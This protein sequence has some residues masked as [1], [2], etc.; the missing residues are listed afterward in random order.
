MDTQPILL[1]LLRGFHVAMLASLFGTLVSQGLV[2]PAALRGAAVAAPVARHRLLRLARWSAALALLLGVGW[3][4]LASAAIAGTVTLSD[5]VAVVGKVAR[6]TR[7]GQLLLFRLALLAVALALLARRN[8]RVVA[9]LLPAGVALGM[10]GLLGHAGA[11]GGSAGVVLLASEAVHLLAAGAWLGGLPP[12]L[13]LVGSL[14]PAAAAEACEN[15]TPVGLGAVVAIAGT[16]AIQSWQLIGGLA[17]LLGTPYGHLALLKA[18]LFVALL[19]LAGVNR[20]VLTGRLRHPLRAATRPA[21]L[22]SIGTETGLGVA[23]IVLAAFLASTMPATHS[24]PVWPFPHHPVPD[25]LADPVARDRSP[26][27]AASGR[28]IAAHPT[29]V[30]AGG[31]R[32]LAP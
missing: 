16:A 28:D 17:R 20:L 14:P 13:L 7:F 18:G 27:R 22:A 1:A 10:Q 5:T 23:V 24:V 29:A 9:A 2:A 21:L 6:M 8:P 32:G 19:V 30:V 11:A 3:M 25:R 26:A 31:G 4:L 15:F 12:L